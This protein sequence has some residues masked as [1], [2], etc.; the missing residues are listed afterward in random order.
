MLLVAVERLLVVDDRP[1]HLLAQGTL[2]LDLKRNGLGESFG[3]IICLI[4]MFRL[5]P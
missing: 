1:E 3:K 2:G 5:L 4:A